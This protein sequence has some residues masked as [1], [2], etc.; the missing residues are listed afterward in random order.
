MKSVMIKHMDKKELNRIQIRLE[1]EAVQKN[2]GMCEMYIYCEY[3]LER[4]KL[5]KESDYPCAIAL[6]RM[7]K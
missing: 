7:K 5:I 3:C 6:L 2:G 4:Y 1:K